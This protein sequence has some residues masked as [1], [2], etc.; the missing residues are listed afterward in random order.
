MNKRFSLIFFLLVAGWFYP[1]I[2]YATEPQELVE[3]YFEAMK[4]GDVKTMKSYMGGKLY[5]KRK[6]LLEENKEYPK[7]LIDFYKG[8]ELETVE[9]KDEIVHIKIQFPDGGK[10]EHN[11][12]L[13]KNSYG[14]WK[15]VNELSF[16]R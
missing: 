9:V 14:K 1:A 5:Q 8:A 7:F 2:T 4:N 3:A 6:V 15:I 12:V 13:Q 10:R 16:D 11:L